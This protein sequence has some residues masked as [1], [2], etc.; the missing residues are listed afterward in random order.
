MNDR[1][2]ADGAGCLA[3]ER[4]DLAFELAHAGFPGVIFDDMAQRGIREFDHFAL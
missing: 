4:G 1:V 2:A 3:R